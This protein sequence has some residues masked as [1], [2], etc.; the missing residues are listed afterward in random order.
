MEGASPGE[1]VGVGRYGHGE[2]ARGGLGV[3]RAR[4]LAGWGAWE[5]IFAGSQL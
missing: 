5:A 1:V 3:V 4:G 2:W